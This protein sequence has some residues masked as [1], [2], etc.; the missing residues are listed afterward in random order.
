LLPAI[1]SW[2]GIFS[3]LNSAYPQVL[4]SSWI[5]LLPFIAKH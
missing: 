4:D 1:H 5:G 2:T 3:R